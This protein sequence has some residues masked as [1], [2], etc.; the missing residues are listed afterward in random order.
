MCLSHDTLPKKF[1]TY[2]LKHTNFFIWPYHLNQEYNKSEI[3]LISGGW[4]D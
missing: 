1:Q 3:L 2:Y 4:V